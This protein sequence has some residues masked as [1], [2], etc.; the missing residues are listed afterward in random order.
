MHRFYFGLKPELRVKCNGSDKPGG[1]WADLAALSTYAQTIDTAVHHEVQ[2]LAQG[3]WRPVHNKKHRGGTGGNNN[4]RYGNGGG[5]GKRAKH[6]TTVK[7]YNHGGGGGGPPGAG[8]IKAGGSA[9]NKGNNAKDGWFADLS[10]DEYKR[11]MR[12]GLC[13]KCGG[14]GHRASDCGKSAK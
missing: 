4:N 13:L 2:E 3:A 6:D 14:E 12:K 10:K 7:V 8:G 5:S 1:W 11:R 9:G